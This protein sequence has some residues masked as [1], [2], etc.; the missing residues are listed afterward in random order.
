MKKVRIHHN[1]DKRDNFKLN[2]ANPSRRRNKMM[3]YSKTQD[4]QTKDD[5]L[6]PTF[7]FKP[8]QNSI[9]SLDCYSQNKS[10]PD[11]TKSGHQVKLTLEAKS[12]KGFKLNCKGYKPRHRNN[13]EKQKFSISKYIHRYKDKISINQ[14]KC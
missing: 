2:S 9:Q 7:L 5:V 14:S 11:S 6:N 4:S 10:N 13:D 3:K 1:Y 12:L 8:I